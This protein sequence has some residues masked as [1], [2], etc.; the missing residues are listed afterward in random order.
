MTVMIVVGSRPFVQR[1]VV[2]GHIASFGTFV[3]SESIIRRCFDFDFATT[4]ALGND[5]AN[6]VPRSQAFRLLR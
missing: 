2:V 4:S 5:R 3:R 6:V 1:F